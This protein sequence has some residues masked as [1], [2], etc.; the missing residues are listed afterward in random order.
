LLLE[1]RD[2]LFNDLISKKINR[3]RGENIE[4]IF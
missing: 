1:I 4:L 2:K 3:R